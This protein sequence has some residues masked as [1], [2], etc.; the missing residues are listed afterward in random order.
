MQ[1]PVA[2]QFGDRAAGL[3]A[4]VERQPWIWPPDTALSLTAQVCGDP[5][6]TD[7]HERGGKC[8][9]IRDQLAVHIKNV[10]PAFPSRV[11]SPSVQA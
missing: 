4:R 7:L 9:V 10:Q 1:Q 11:R 8:V 2:H 6:L 3:E 5:V